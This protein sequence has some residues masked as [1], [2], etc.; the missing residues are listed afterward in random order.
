MARFTFNLSQVVRYN[1]YVD[2]PTRMDALRKL[3]RDLQEADGKPIDLYE[4]GSD[5][6]T[7]DVGLGESRDEI[8]DGLRQMQRCEDSDGRDRRAGQRI[9]RGYAAERKEAPRQS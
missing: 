6:L 5:G 2:G 8:D 7:I 1:V 4:I 9:Q 3:V